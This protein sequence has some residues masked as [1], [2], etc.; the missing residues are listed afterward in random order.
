MNNIGAGSNNSPHYFVILFIFVSVTVFLC[1]SGY[2]RKKELRKAKQAIENASTRDP[3]WKEEKLVECAREIFL[4]FQ[5]DWSNFNIDSMK[6]YLTNSYLEKIGLEMSILKNGYRQNLIKDIVIESIVI[7]DAADS[8]DDTLDI[9]SVEISAHSRNIIMNTERNS[10]IFVDNMGSIEHWDFVRDGDEWKLNF[11]RQTSDNVSLSDPKVESFAKRNNFFYDPEFGKLMKPIYGTIF[12]VYDFAL[13][14]I[15]NLVIG[16]YQ[17][18]IVEFYKFSSGSPYRIQNPFIVAQTVLPIKYK[19][20]LIRRKSLLPDVGPSGLRH[21][22]TESNDFNKKFNLWADPEDQA[23]SFELLAPNFMEKI[24]EL[25]FELNIEIVD[26]FLYFYVKD[27][28]NVDYDKMLEILSWAFDE[29][30]M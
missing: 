25:P 16:K 22:E 14:R 15:K 9:F 28:S 26:S 3:I 27:E 11:I 30:K 7:I 17:G 20:I 21:I 29:M 10:E 24:Y 13:S 18:K 23:N 8:E 12:S 6:V 19:N 4:K 1:W 2:R 5:N